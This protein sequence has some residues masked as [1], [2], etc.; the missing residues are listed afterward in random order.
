MRNTGAARDGEGC[1]AASNRSL[2]TF[3]VVAAARA[4]RERS[5]T[6]VIEGAWG[7]TGA[8]VERVRVGALDHLMLPQY[9]PLCK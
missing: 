8:L 9:A 6:D 5:D 7:C 3:S 2:R 1:W 4:G